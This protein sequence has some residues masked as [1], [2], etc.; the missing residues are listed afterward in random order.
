MPDDANTLTATDDPVE[1]I[2]WDEEKIADILDRIASKEQT[3]DDLVSE[4]EKEHLVE[5]LEQLEEEAR[6]ILGDY[7]HACE[8]HDEKRRAELKKGGHSPQEVEEILDRDRLQIV[9]RALRGEGTSTN[10]AHEYYAAG[11]QVGYEPH[12]AHVAKQ[13][14]LMDQL[15]NDDPEAFDQMWDMLAKI[16]RLG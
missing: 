16:G 1:W 9:A 6:E 11:H 13:A 8:H 12:P 2:E 4:A 14:E 7:D 15:A 10:P 3:D 5:T